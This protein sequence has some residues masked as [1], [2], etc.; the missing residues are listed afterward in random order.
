MKRFVAT[1]G[2]N[3]IAV[4]IFAAASA[5]AETGHPTPPMIDRDGAVRVAAQVYAMPSSFSDEARKAFTDYF[6]RGG[7]PAMTG[8]IDNIRRIYDTQWAGPILAEWQ[9]RYPVTMQRT[10]MAG[11]DVD[12]VQPRDGVAPGKKD[13]VLISLH[14]GGFVIGN[15]GVGGRME[16][17]PMAGIGGF[18]VIA[19]DYR[20]APEARYPAA[21]D[22]VVAVYRELLKS[23]APGNIGIVGSSAGGMLAAQTVARLQN[24]ELPRPGAIAIQA[25]G[26]SSRG[27]SDS[28]FW[29]LG[30]TGAMVK[31]PEEMPKLPSYFA[32]EDM[33]DP[34]AFPADH[35]GILAQFPPTLILSSSRDSLLGNALDT[36]AR[37]REA[38]VDSQLYVRHGFGHG[39]FTQVPQVP[40]AIHAWQET[41]AHFDRHLGKTAPD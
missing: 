41:V 19:V 12:I 34:L 2:R 40:E 13:R 26:A 21:T 17:I 37:L 1:L 39:Y 16:A 33:K 38:N 27:A 5:V 22:D 25:A 24:E 15:G 35:P 30:L 23:Y 4:S 10:S 6:A 8:D 9:A 18:R 14:G 7:D 36:H 3:A 20:Q 11:V 29:M 32:P 28:Q 31:L